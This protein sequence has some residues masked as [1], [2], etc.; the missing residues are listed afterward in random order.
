VK[1]SR[2]PSITEC[3]FRVLGPTWRRLN[4]WI[5]VTDGLILDELPNGQARL[6][7][8]RFDGVNRRS[9]HC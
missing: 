1:Y 5:A 9:K 7:F 2:R 8:C 3:D 4:G 6:S